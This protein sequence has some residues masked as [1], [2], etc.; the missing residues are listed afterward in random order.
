MPNSR[1]AGM[2]SSLAS[3][4]SSTACEIESRSTPGIASMGVRLSVPSSMN[5][6]WTRWDGVRS[7]SR[8][9]PRSRPVLRSRRMR[10]AGKAIP[11][12]GY[13]G[14]RRGPYARSVPLL[15]LSAI[16]RDRPGIVAALTGV[17]LDHG[18]NI[19]DSQATIL[20]GHFSIVLIVATPDELDR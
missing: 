1:T 9:R 12:A 2:P 15:A 6:G 10:V 13:L 19:E 3:P 17:L 11:T 7:V 20:R 14:R 5:I 18:L 4:A 8:T 16:G